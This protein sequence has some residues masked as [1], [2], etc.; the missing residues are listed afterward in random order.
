[1]P[2]TKVHNIQHGIENIPKADIYI[3][4][5][6]A[7]PD[8]MRSQKA[9]GARIYWDVCDPVW[10]WH[11]V[12]EIKPIVDMIDGAAASSVE[13]AVQFKRDLGR[14]CNYIPD[15]L[16]LEH[17]KLYRNHERQ[18]IIRFIWY[19]VAVN[20]ISLI[21]ALPYLE[22][23]KI[24]TGLNI[25]LTIFDDR[26]DKKL[27]A[28]DIIPVYTVPWSLRHE[29]EVIASHDIAILPKYPGPWGDVKSNNK[30][31]TAYACGLPVV[32][33]DNYDYM[34]EMVSRPTRRQ[35]DAND[36][37]LLVKRSYL[38]EQSA[39]DWLKWLAK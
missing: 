1:M 12:T 18:E 35:I 2:D 30:D 13:L 22:R 9:S 10:W 4:Q 3:W 14:E 37:Y 27:G 11:P 15:R 21:G 6:V 26:P 19:G 24:Q 29:N 36:G 38:S 39:E 33:G 34:Y 8:I 20:R 5:K 16:E 17:F 23:L 32:R 7:E 25:S 31:L 28:T